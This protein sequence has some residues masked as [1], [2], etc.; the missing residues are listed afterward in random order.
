LSYAQIEKTRDVKEMQNEMEELKREVMV[1]KR[2]K[3]EHQ[4]QKENLKHLSGKDAA[5][6]AE[7][8]FEMENHNAEMQS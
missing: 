2:E 8:E 6:V 7:L 1:L 4:E 3:L 5:R